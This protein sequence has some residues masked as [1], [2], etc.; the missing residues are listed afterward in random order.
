MN[1][2]I[3]TCGWSVK[4]GRKEYYKY[5][6]V[7]ELQDTFYRLPKLNTVKKWRSEAPENFEFTLKAWQ[8]MTHTPKSP[9]WRKNNIKVKKEDFKKYGFFRPTNEVFSAWEKFRENAKMLNAKIIVFQTPPSFKC[10]RENINNMKEFFNSIDRNRFILCWEPRGN[11][12]E[13]ENILKQVLE[14]LN[15]VHVVDILKRKPLVYRNILY[16]RMHGLGKGEVNYRYKYND[17]DLQKIKNII[18]S[19][20]HEVREVYVMFN[21]I[22]MFHDAL[23]LKKMLS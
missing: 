5:F 3:G 22:F 2:K 21:N 7:I 16:F 15:L 1:V 23:R 8:T 20:Q 11:W 9:T 13:N 10:T 6:N 17:K 19:L 18:F 12:Y 4:G 14:N